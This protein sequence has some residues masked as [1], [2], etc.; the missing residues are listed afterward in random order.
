M[1]KTFLIATAL[2]FLLASNVQAKKAEE[3]TELHPQKV[4]SIMESE[5]EENVYRLRG[6]EQLIIKFFGYDELNSPTNGTTPYILSPDG[7]FYMP[8]IGEVDALGRT[9]S[10]ICEEIETRYKKYLRYPVVDIN[11]MQVSKIRVCVLG[12]VERQGVYAFDKAPRLLEAIASAWGFVNKSSKKNV[13]V[14]RAGEDE[15]CLKIDL[16][17]FL[18]GESTG[19][20]IILNEGDCVYITSNNKVSFSKDIQPFFS[21]MYYLDRLE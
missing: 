6:G 15:P 8:L 18:K 17:K 16:R 2:T 9:V 7:K 1:R 4:P 11:I 12:Q 3:I 21:S 13:F 20:N 5:R 14:I 10:D 19:H